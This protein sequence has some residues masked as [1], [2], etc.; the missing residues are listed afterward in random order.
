MSRKPVTVTSAD[1]ARL[2]RAVARVQDHSQAEVEYEG[3]LAA[4]V[5]SLAGIQWSLRGDGLTRYAVA[6]GA[7]GYKVVFALAEFDSTITK[8]SILLAYQKSG[9][10]LDDREGPCRLVLP[11]QK[12]GARSI[13]QLVGIEV[14]RAE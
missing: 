12:R 14:R 9:A 4:D 5:L 8:A 7:D 2:P 1:L 3:A 13:R 10:A 6:V 11:D